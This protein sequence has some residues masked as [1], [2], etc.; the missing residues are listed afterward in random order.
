M[1]P[2]RLMVDEQGFTR[3]IEG[4]PNAQVCLKSNEA[5]FLT[6]LTERIVR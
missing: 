3:R 1:E 4:P 2:M 5:G 6:L